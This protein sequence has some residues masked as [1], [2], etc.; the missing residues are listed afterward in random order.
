MNSTVYNNCNQS[1]EQTLSA[2]V[3]LELCTVQVSV[4]WSIRL[5]LVHMRHRTHRSSELLPPRT[6]VGRRGFLNGVSTLDTGRLERRLSHR[7]L[8]SS[9]I[10]LQQLSV[11]THQCVYSR[12]SAD[13]RVRRCWLDLSEHEHL[14][15]TVRKL[16]LFICDQKK[17][18]FLQFFVF[19]IYK[20]LYT[21]SK[22]TTQCVSISNLI[23]LI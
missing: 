23:Y 1:W 18:E 2:V 11:Q 10:P 8:V 13:A 20:K 7:C 16:Y 19:E 9:V 21:L 6:V 14:N 12:E 5:H 17:V 4:V 22:T 15:Q 3:L